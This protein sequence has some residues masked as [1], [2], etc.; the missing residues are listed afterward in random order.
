MGNQSIG[1][2]S[3]TI[4]ANAQQLIDE[5]RRAQQAMD[6]NTAAITKGA[7]KMAAGMEQGF[8]RIAL[9][10]HAFTLVRNEVREVIKQIDA[11]PNVSADTIES[12]HRLKFAFEDANGGLKSYVATLV[13]GVATAVQFTTNRLAGLIYGL[14]AADEG[15][16]LLNSAAEEFAAKKYTA[17]LEKITTELAHMKMSAGQLG[18]QFLIEMQKLNAFS[19]GTAGTQQERWDASLKAGKDLIEVQK[20]LN[21]LKKEDEAILQRLTKTDRS[22]AN[23]GEDPRKRIQELQKSRDE[24]AQQKFDITGKSI[25]KGLSPSDAEAILKIDTARLRVNEELIPLLDKEQAKYQKIVNLVGDN[26]TQAFVD[27]G[28]GAQD[29]FRNL[30]KTILQEIEKI[31]VR[32]LIVVPL[33]QA[34]G[35]AFE[36]AGGGKAG[37][38]TSL[39]NAFTSYAGAK[40]GGGDIGQGQFALVGENGPEILAK[41]GTVI[42]N[43]K[44]AA[45]VGSAGSGRGASVTTN[46]TYNI[47]NGVTRQE[48]A[49]LIPSLIKQTKSAVAEEV[50]RGGAYRKAFA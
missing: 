6:Q 12:I 39:G 28:N 9:G 27:A 15:W 37:V 17:D 44:I 4:T 36:A 22:I 2:L 41:P 13:G 23:I 10:S 8:L 1:N 18:E 20:I 21:T 24:L 25:G 16:A 46:V 38:F 43:D 47:G 31:I 30:G 40:A 26:L 34:I 5:F 3:A 11:I 29:A 49:G 7:D 45:A 50:R 19:Q 48:L 42:S 33:M 14:S 32:A 35:G